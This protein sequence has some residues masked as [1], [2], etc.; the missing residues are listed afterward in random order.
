[1]SESPA[2]APESV[3]IARL[4]GEACWECGAANTT[5]YPA[6]AVATEAGK[7]WQIRKCI[8]HRDLTELQERGQACVHCGV[9]LDNRCA[10][11]LG[12]R[13]VRRGGH[14]VS[15]FPR[16]CPPHGALP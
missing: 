13:L 1:M 11:D 5:L 15:W 14:L 9:I 2:S 12:A 4:H 6:G 8:S 3:S 16:A 7:E 10:I